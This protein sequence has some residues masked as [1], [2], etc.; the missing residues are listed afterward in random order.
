MKLVTAPVRQILKADPR[1]SV[2]QSVAVLTSDTQGFGRRRCKNLFRI[3][4]STA[5]S[6]PPSVVCRPLIRSIPI[7]STTV[8]ITIKTITSIASFTIWPDER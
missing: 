3:R 4:S 8:I 6:L 7:N 1:F 2:M 5:F